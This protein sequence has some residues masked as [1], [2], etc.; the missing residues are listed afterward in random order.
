M[1]SLAIRTDGDI[2]IDGGDLVLDHG[3]VSSIL[4]S[5]FCDAWVP[6]R[7]PEDQ[8]GYWADEVGDA[9]GSQI[10]LLER[11]KATQET[12]AA[13]ADHARRSLRWLVQE[14]IAQDVRVSASY[15]RPGFLALD[16]EIERG[17]ARR[18]VSLWEAFEDFEDEYAAGAVRLRGIG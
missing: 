17:T 8:R 11:A 9:V 3:L 1:T 4:V 10:W 12:A 13:A 2:A 5:L 14:G 18:W 15:V 16:V 7:K 6:G